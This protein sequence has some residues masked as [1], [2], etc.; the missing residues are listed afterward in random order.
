MLDTSLGKS[1]LPLSG[2]ESSLHHHGVSR[3]I[4]ILTALCPILKRTEISQKYGQN[5]SEY[6]SKW[7]ELVQRKGGNYF[8]SFIYHPFAT[9]VTLGLVNQSIRQT[10]KTNSRTYYKELHNSSQEYHIRISVQQAECDLQITML[11]H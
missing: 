5:F 4:T 7:Y 1:L 2:A 6:R 10:I 8:I 3:L 9:S 11:S